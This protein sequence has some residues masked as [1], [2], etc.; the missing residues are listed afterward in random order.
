ME[1]LLDA[2]S[3]GRSKVRMSAPERE[4]AAENPNWKPG[5]QSKQAAAANQG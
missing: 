5:A 2:T 4:V 3:T 1:A